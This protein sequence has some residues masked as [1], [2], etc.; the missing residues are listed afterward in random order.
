MRLNF[1]GASYSQ[2]YNYNL[3]IILSLGGSC[4][5]S[6]VKRNHIQKK[7]MLDVHLTLEYN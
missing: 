4:H 7:I 2:L 3:R 5:V 6:S 1:K